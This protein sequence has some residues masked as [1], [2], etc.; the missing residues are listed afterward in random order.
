MVILLRKKIQRER[1]W[2][3]N[4]NEERDEEKRVKRASNQGGKQTRCEYMNSQYI[5]SHI[6]QRAYIMII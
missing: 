2:G 1:N 3:R 4:K 5:I 6:N